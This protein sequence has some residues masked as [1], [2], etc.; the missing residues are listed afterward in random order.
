[1]SEPTPIHIP[2]MLDEVLAGLNLRDGSIIVDG[3]LGLAGHSSEI[4]K[5]ISPSGKLIGIDHDEKALLKAKE[6][7]VEFAGQC[8]FAQDNFKNIDQV[9]HDL[10]VEKVDGI[11]LDL[12]VSSLQLDDPSRGFSVKAS[13]PLDM[14]MD[15]GGARTAFDVVNSFSESEL[16]DILRDY[17]EE[18]WHKRIA[19]RIVY[20]R[21]NNPIETT[22]ELS[23]IILKAMPPRKK[24]QRLHPATRTFQAI[25]I[26]V[27]EELD[28]LKDALEKCIDLLSEN[29]RIVVIA[30]H[31][32]EDRIVKHKF[33]ELS[34]SG[35]VRL[36]TKKP[37]RPT[38]EEEKINPRSRS[39]R[40]R[41]AERI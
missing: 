2:V 17:G 13:G 23:R 37:L 5:V 40:L 29:G 28:S 39:A 36:I 4:L 22:D 10:E 16:S 25:R 21:I 14:R 24:W 26:V 32:L 35:A 8:D 15:Q 1:M 27:N 3:T 12:G 20:E 38:Q 34:K 19:S 11:L 6:K 41:I 18:R 9:L 31:S 33:R 7:L 30:F